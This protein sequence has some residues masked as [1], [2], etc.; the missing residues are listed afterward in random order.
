MT[1]TERTPLNDNLPITLAEAK[2][3]TRITF[4]DD[5]TAIADMIRSAAADVEAMTGLALLATTITHTTGDC[6][7]SIIDLPVGPV[8]SGAVATVAVIE[9]DGSATAVASGFWLEGGRYP[10]L[11][12][13]TTPGGRLRI[14]Y[15]AGYGEDADSVPRD[16]GLAICEQAARL[17]DQRGG[18]SDKGPALSAHTARVIARYRRV[19]L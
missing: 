10:R 16:L 13:T 8:A 18:I 9:L 11:H 6:P 2:E 4:S 1:T 19:R 7:G 15:P 12:F 5:D 14:T 17:Y 3:H